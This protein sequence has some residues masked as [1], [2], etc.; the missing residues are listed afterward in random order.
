MS[1]TIPDIIASVVPDRY[2]DSG[3]SI[4][5]KH[6]NKLKE[7]KSLLNSVKEKQKEEMGE[8]YSEEQALF[9]AI[10][11]AKE[12]GILGAKSEAKHK[13]NYESPTET[14]EPI[15]FFILDLV[16]DFGFSTEKLIDNFVSSPGSGHFGEMGQRASIMQQQGAK[17]LGDINTVLRSIINIVY[18]L[19]EMTIFL[20][21]YE[22]LK[23]EDKEVSEAAR[24]SLKQRWMDK[25]DVNKGNSSI[26]AMALGQSNFVTLIDAFL[27]AKN[28]EDVEKMD[29]NSMVKRILK[30]RIAEFN[31][32]IIYSESEL[33][34][35]HEIEKQYLK[36]QVD[37]LKLYSSWAK[38]Y[39]RASQEL[40]MSEK[41]HNPSLVKMFNTMLL[42]LTLLCT[43]KFKAGE[44]WD[45]LTLGVNNIPASWKYNPKHDFYEV[46]VIDFDFRGM[47]QRTQQ[48]YVAGGRTRM[49]FNAY[50]MTGEELKLFRKVYE[51]TDL[52]DALQLVEGVTNDSL[53]S[54][55]KDINFFLYDIEEKEEKKKEKK[56]EKTPDTSN[57]FLALV[58]AYNKKEE[59]KKPAE[60]KNG[61]SKR[62]KEAESKYI[63]PAVQATVKDTV[64]NFFEIYKKVH[65]MAAF[66]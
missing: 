25:V 39:L 35:R 65:G 58:G 23:S 41:T 14:L 37:S 11:E 1:V 64:F 32:W 18:D 42:E 54:L 17:L 21:P 29:L 40:Q 13:L 8:A 19:R 26:K 57:P 3:E 63:V 24:L 43:R 30:P 61:L 51:K 31:H 2:Y 4:P 27:I 22:E 9:D 46:V 28:P 60:K 7:F 56:K 62:D 33:K 55:T 20:K 10:K 48:G 52:D 36:S 50:V 44:P 34:K 12:K 49:T 53:G 66:P 38:P 16:E 15:Y 47:P 45:D 59:K 5:P 6:K